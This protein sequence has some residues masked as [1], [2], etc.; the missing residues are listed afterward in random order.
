MAFMRN[1][2]ASARLMAVFQTLRFDDITAP[3]PSEASLA[4]ECA[5]IT[6]LLDAARVT[7]R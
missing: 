1:V 7:W 4:A 5:A 2:T 6:A 3:R